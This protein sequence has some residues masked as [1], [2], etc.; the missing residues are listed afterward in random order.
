M[1]KIICNTIDFVF[2]NEIEVMN[3]GEIPVLKD[4]KAWK[5]INA[6]EKPVYQSNIKQFDAGPTDEETVTV[7]ARHNNIMELLITCCGFY[8]ILRM[9]T[10]EKTFYVGN[11]EYPCLLEIISDKVFDNFTF[12]AVSPA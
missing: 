9:S 4:G 8:T 11:I 10:D 2:R 6:F 3:E 1:S 5:K 12:K 7:H